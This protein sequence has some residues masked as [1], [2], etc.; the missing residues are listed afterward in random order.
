MYTRNL[1]E[2]ISLTRRP[3]MRVILTVLLLALG[4]TGCK[5]QLE[6]ETFV[7]VK[8]KLLEPEEITVSSKFSGSVEPLQTT[9]LAFKLDGTVDKLYRPSNLNRDVQV[10]DTLQKGTVIAELEDGDLRRAKQSAEAKVLELEARVATAK[11]N[12]EI[13]ARNFKRFTNSAGSVSKTARDDADGKRVT[14][15]GELSSAEQALADARIKL[16]QARDD[17]INR[18]LLV[19]FNEATVAEK[20]VEPGERVQRNASVFK[21]IDISTVHVRFGVPDTMIGG[22]AFSN[23]SSDRVFL[24]Q[25]LRIVSD[26]FTGRSLEAVV[27]KI[28]PQADSKT[29]TFLTELTV[30][31]PEL[32]GGQRLLRPGMIVT[33]LVGAEHD[34]SVSLLPMA[35]IHRGESPEDRIVYEAVEENGREVA[36]VRKVRLGGVFNNMVEVIPGESEVK[37]GAKVVLTTAERLTDSTLIRVVHDNQSSGAILTEAR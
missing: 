5:K 31:N 33:V 19:P 11:D 21:L 12:L 4:T 32:E 23:S 14:A 7:P 36:R 18:Q 20:Q 3:I 24:G 28:S 16:D 26:A 10:G 9:T 13:A 25:K 6:P 22:S 1:D 37:S 35:A 29:R 30:P 17:Y 27:T 8:V 2:R 15:A 34:R